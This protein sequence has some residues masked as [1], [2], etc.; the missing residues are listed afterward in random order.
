[1]KINN[2]N[3]K[4]LKE[5]GIKVPSYHRE[6]LKRECVHIGLGH[7]HR[8]HFLTYMDK[9]LDAKISDSGVFEIDIVP[10]GPVG[11]FFVALTLS[12]EIGG[13]EPRLV[14]C[15]K[16]SNRVVEICVVHR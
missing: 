12:S 3:L 11:E 10:L 4:A 14:C 9:L 13:T 2:E 6:S 15:T 16:K 1:M 7:F 8:S 5:M